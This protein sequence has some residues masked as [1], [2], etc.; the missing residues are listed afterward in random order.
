MRT[1]NFVS[2]IARL[3]LLA[4]LT[5]TASGQSLPDWE[6][7]TLVTTPAE[8]EVRL[9]NELQR[10]VE[11]ENSHHV[12]LANGELIFSQV[13]MAIRGR[14]MDF[15]WKRTYRS[16]HDVDG[17]MGRNW[18]HS[19][20]IRVQTSGA[21]LLLQDGT[22]RVDRYLPSGTNTWAAVGHTRT[23]ELDST[24]GQF[25][26]THQHGG[27]WLL[28]PL[29]SAWGGRLEAIE[30]KNLNRIEFQ[31]D[32]LGR[33]EAIVDTLGRTINVIYGPGGRIAELE[34]F[35][36]EYGVSGRGRVV[37]YGYYADVDSGGNEGDLA[38]VTSPAVVGTSTGNDFPSG[39]TWTFVYD[40][41]S[42]AGLRHNL[43]AAFDPA[44]E[45]YFACVYG[46]TTGALNFDAVVSQVLPSGPNGAS[47][48]HFV[49]VTQSPATGNNYATS[50]TIVNDR[51]GNVRELFYDGANLC[52]YRMFTGR[53]DPS[54]P[55][56][57]TTNRPASP[58]RPGDPTFFET[59][60]TVNSHGL[61]TAI[62]HPNGAMTE[63]LYDTASSDPRG[64]ANLLREKRFPGPLGAD[65]SELCELWSYNSYYHLVGEHRDAK[66]F[67]SQTTYDGAG[68]NESLGS[69]ETP[70]AL[71]SLPTAPLTTSTGGGNAVA[72]TC[73]EENFLAALVQ[74]GCCTSSSYNTY[75]QP[76]QVVAS[77]GAVY[78]FT[79]HSS[80]PMEG[81]LASLTFDA[82]GAALLFEYEYDS[83]GNTTLIRDPSGKEV[84]F[85][86]N[87]LSRV[88]QS[89]Y[90]APYSYV[91]QYYYNLQDRLVRIEISNVDHTGIADPLNPW[92]TTEHEFD[93]LGNLTRIEEEASAT[94]VVVAEMAYDANENRT[95]LRRG[96]SVNGNQVGNIVRWAWDERDRLFTRTR[97]LGAAESTSR[98]DYDLAGNLQL[99]A[100]GIE[101]SAPRI[102]ILEHDGFDRLRLTIDPMGNEVHYSYDPNG[103]RVSH[104]VYGEVVDAPGGT[105][106]VLLRNADFTYDARDRRKGTQVDLF[107]VSLG[108]VST[109]LPGHPAAWGFEYTGEDKL[110]AVVD[111]NDGRIEYRRDAL[112][113]LIEVEDQVQNL[114]RVD[115]FDAIGNPQTQSTIDRST[116]GSGLDETFVSQM[117]HDSLSRVVA[118]VDNALN[119]HAY[120]YDARDNLR[121]TVDPEGHQVRYD[122][123]GLDR[124]VAIVRDMDGD[125]PDENDV[126]DVVTRSVWDDS[127]RLIASI[128]D[129]GRTTRYAW[130][131]L[132]RII[133]LRMA[134]GTLLQVG[135]G[136]VWPDGMAR[137]NLAGFVTGYDVHDNPLVLTDANGTT[138]YSTFDLNDRVVSKTIDRA[139]VTSGDPTN[140]LGTTSESFLYDGLDRVVLAANNEVQVARQYDSNDNV[141]QE[142]IQVLTL[143]WRTTLFEHDA[144]GNIVKTTYP[145]GTVVEYELDALDRRSV[146]SKNGNFWAGYDFVGASR[147]SRRDLA[148]G[149]RTTYGYDADRRPVSLLS[150]QDFGLGATVAH[151]TATWTPSDSVEVKSDVLRSRE[152][153]A[154]Y[155]PLDRLTGRD[156][157]ESN[158]NTQ[159]WTYL[160]DGVQNRLS[161]EQGPPTAP[162]ASAYSMQSGAPYYDAEVNQYT[163]TPWHTLRWDENGNLAQ[164]LSG[165]SVQ[166]S[167]AYDYRNLQVQ[168]TDAVA[169]QVH[170]Y[171]YDAFGRRAYKVS[172]LGGSAQDIRQFSYGG[173][174]LWQVIEEHNVASTLLVSYVHGNYVDEVISATRTAAA[175]AAGSYFLLHDHQFSTVALTDA[176]GDLVESYA[177]DDFGGVQFRN[178]AGATI[179]ASL[180][181]NDYLFTGREWDAASRLYQYR[182]RYMDPKV[183]HFT[184]RDT[185]GNW[186]DAANL[187]N[188]R[189][190]VGN[191][192]WSRVDPSGQFFETL[193]D[194]ANVLY[195]A[196]RAVK[197]VAEAGYEGARYG[198]NK[199]T[200]DEA[201]AQDAAAELKK[202]LGELGE[203]GLDLVLDGIAL[204]LPVVPAGGQRAVRAAAGAAD[205]LA[206]GV[207]RVCRGPGAGRGGAYDF[208]D[209]P[210]VGDGKKLTQSQKDKVR[211]ENKAQNGGQ[212]KSD[213]SGTDLVPPK[214]HE[215]GVTPPSNEAH[216]DHIKPRSQGGSNS[217]SNAQV[218]SRQENL[219]KGAGGQ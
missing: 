109:T 4:V 11:A 214:Q 148:N 94:Q 188:G 56:T 152:D 190:Y 59:R 145:S 99:V 219:Q 10:D 163:S 178:A 212:L 194:A 125:G 161:T 23:I 108:G 191:N 45:G 144:K 74:S 6:S 176:L 189:G 140:V 127:S 67:E 180:V 142:S 196:G 157:Y 195:D 149:I 207:A 173:E 150:Q 202:D 168:V 124:I 40:E 90:Q 32:V 30:D 175:G 123:D 86:V 61:I 113:R 151:H 110:F 48:Y 42:V 205:D 60:Y 20:D 203:A 43:L 84:T 217:F 156:L 37:T 36:T 19:Y 68:F 201:G 206:E 111:P 83:L 169:G 64:R 15:V 58:L 159:V 91:R 73:P 146:V 54:Q 85:E 5:T 162:V 52:L 69:C 115:V 165:S 121:F 63:W 218:I 71:A 79:Y 1:S 55:T 137:P 204:A 53:A 2:L 24:S 66:G 21:D 18:T 33:L 158:A 155:D 116:L 50:K 35:A 200:G 122:Y 160:Y 133:G 183:G 49:Y 46:T 7:P 135:T 213:I 153:R 106:N 128:D 134:D 187:G 3:L 210:S 119:A 114:W 166:R 88:V 75:G 104:S 192:P 29:G 25:T 171:G 184:T 208:P 118:Q 13:D 105:G 197:N 182:T 179:S 107:K 57:E 41:S 8:P 78:A 100:H 126:D 102:W 199:L 16:R 120:F 181:D 77:T 172:D 38:S 185:V 164:E 12:S 96:E 131:A 138:I 174:S 186:G 139:A 117:L 31:Y 26:V 70:L 39:K 93:T 62:E 51:M 112:D 198:I 76:L 136:M 65:Q 9:R 81:Y 92:L 101:I 82:N 47:S 170:I 17:P 141:I 129:N 103:N 193:W 209:H 44:A 154:S 80:G 147:V 27:R 143:Q 216:V 177:Y 95:L 97:G 87:A 130:D 132:D 89:T 22:G 211:D 167:F 215:K 28:A 34:D 72:G 98:Y 14:G